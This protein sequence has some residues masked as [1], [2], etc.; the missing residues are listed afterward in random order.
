MALSNCGRMMV[1]RDRGTDGAGGEHGQWQTQ[2]QG[3]EEDKARLG[4][5][6]SDERGKKAVGRPLTDS[7]RKVSDTARTVL[8]FRVYMDRRD[9]DFCM[10]KFGVKF[11]TY[12]GHYRMFQK[13]NPSR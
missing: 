7:T 5:G 9:R 6:K 10:Q 4:E 1:S 8:I 11:A 2:W 13:I 12:R 3:I